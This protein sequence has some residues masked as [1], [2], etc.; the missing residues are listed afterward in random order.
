MAKGKLENLVA[1]DMKNGFTYIGLD[2]QQSDFRNHAILKDY[3]VVPTSSLTQTSGYV[4]RVESA[5][6]ECEKSK[7]PLYLNNV[8]VKHRINAKGE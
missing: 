6:Q 8:E 7:G 2:G 4:G 1:V 3:V 5:Y